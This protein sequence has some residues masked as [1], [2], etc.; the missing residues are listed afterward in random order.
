MRSDLADQLS[1]KGNASHMMADLTQG[2]KVKATTVLNFL[3]IEQRAFSL[4]QELAIEFGDVRVAE[5]IGSFFKFRVDKSKEHHSIGFVF[6][7]LQDIVTKYHIDQYSASQTSLNQIF[8]T[9]AKQA[10]VFFGLYK[11]IFSMG[12]ILERILWL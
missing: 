2:R 6:G 4:A 7:Y 11:M 5:H 8:Q 10:E 12:W 3:F 9:F 1:A